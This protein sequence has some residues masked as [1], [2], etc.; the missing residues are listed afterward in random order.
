MTL[1]SHLLQGPRGFLRMILF[2]FI[3]MLAQG[4]VCKFTAGQDF[5]ANSKPHEFLEPKQTGLEMLEQIPKQYVQ[6]NPEPYYIFSDAKVWKDIVK[7]DEENCRKKCLDYS[8]HKVTEHCVAIEYESECFWTW[9]KTDAQYGKGQTIAFV[10]CDVGTSK[11]LEKPLIPQNLMLDRMRQTITSTCRLYSD[12][13]GTKFEWAI[14]SWDSDAAKKIMTHQ[15][16]KIVVKKVKQKVEGLPGDAQFWS[17]DNLNDFWISRVSHVQNPKEC[18]N[19]RTDNLQGSLTSNATESSEFD[20]LVNGCSSTDIQATMASLQMSKAFCDYN[21]EDCAISRLAFGKSSF[22][23]CYGIYKADLPYIQ[24]E[25]ETSFANSEDMVLNLK[26]DSGNNC[27]TGFF[28]PYS[29]V[30]CPD[31][32]CYTSFDEEKCLYWENPEGPTNFDTCG[33]FCNE[34]DGCDSYMWGCHND[35]WND[36]C[37]CF[38]VS[39]DVVA[40]KDDSQAQQLDMSEHLQMDKPHSFWISKQILEPELDQEDLDAFEGCTPVMFFE[41]AVS[42]ADTYE[43]C[44]IE[45]QT[46]PDGS[47]S[48]DA[49][50]CVYDHLGTSDHICANVAEAIS[51]E[52]TKIEQ[53]MDESNVDPE[54][55][56]ACGWSRFLMC[57]GDLVDAI[58]HC[59]QK[60]DV[61]GYS[62]CVLAESIKSDC[63]KCAQIVVT[64]TVDDKALKGVQDWIKNFVTKVKNINQCSV[65]GWMQCGSDLAT[66]YETCSNKESRLECMMDRTQNTQCAACVGLKS[67][68]SAQKT[69]S[70]QPLNQHTGIAQ[71]NYVGGLL[72]DFSCLTKLADCATKIPQAISQCGMN[73]ACW[74]THALADATQCIPCVQDLLP[75]IPLAEEPQQKENLKGLLPWP[76]SDLIPMPL[77]LQNR[78]FNGAVNLTN[79]VANHPHPGFHCT[80]DD[81]AYDH[82]MFRTDG[83]WSACMQS[84]DTDSLCQ[85]VHMNFA[86]T[87][88][89]W[90]CSLYKSV[91]D[92]ESGVGGEDQYIFVKPGAKDYFLM[93]GSQGVEEV[94]NLQC[95][96]STK[97]FGAFEI[98]VLV[99]LSLITL[100]G[101]LV[102]SVL[103]H[104]R[105]SKTTRQEDATW[106]C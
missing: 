83:Q 98:S 31:S 71:G 40:T 37:Q 60:D 63:E 87:A 24:T 104:Q 41:F 96:N 11:F 42:F 50:E 6:E 91:S 80:N 106:Q 56:N 18:Y 78:D 95:S 73:P 39:K 4:D 23:D 76:F 97:S 25:K 8:L 43:K 67:G 61:A 3:C 16:D 9:D 21:D 92:C 99:L 34:L 93:V 84:C 26:A 48:D 82:F 74:A 58:Q 102:A 69:L 70:S 81:A 14:D 55:N 103:L 38:F 66:V 52:Q 94:D 72:P 29:V 89:G 101:F 79:S 75:L 68:K 46:A 22:S 62:D 20:N 88:N 49:A 17:R 86:A 36:H 90:K 13:Y 2:A 47:I 7:E 85:I 105:N 65:R 28:R 77:F 64:T 19:I 54:E 1:S 32:T 10:Q 51:N 44:L 57:R 5:S 59:T 53:Q 27:L 30:D 100:S 45:L 12:D 35:G 33:M 15:L